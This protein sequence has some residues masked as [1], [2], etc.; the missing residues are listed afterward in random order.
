[1]DTR[2]AATVRIPRVMMTRIDSIDGADCG[3]R[4]GKN[5]MVRIE[6][7]SVEQAMT[8]CRTEIDRSRAQLAS[9]GPNHR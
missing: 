5:Q 8:L 1:M 3:S 2:P 9:G 7:K 6:T 4:S